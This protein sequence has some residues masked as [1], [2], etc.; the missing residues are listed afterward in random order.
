MDEWRR[1]AGERGRSM[2]RVLRQNRL[3]AQ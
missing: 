3:H 1:R 2:E